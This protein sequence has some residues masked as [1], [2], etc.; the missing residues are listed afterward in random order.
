[1]GGARGCDGSGGDTPGGQMRSTN[2]TARCGSG[3]SRT[4]PVTTGRKA[5]PNAKESDFGKI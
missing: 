5:T 3:A 4:T 1:M 2:E